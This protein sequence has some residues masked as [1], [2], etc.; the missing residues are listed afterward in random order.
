[1]RTLQIENDFFGDQ[2]RDRVLKSQMDGARSR[3]S[4]CIEELCIFVGICINTNLLNGGL[5]KFLLDLRWS[6]RQL[7]ASAYFASTKRLC[8]LHPDSIKTII[9]L[10]ILQIFLFFIYYEILHHKIFY[11]LLCV[12]QALIKSSEKRKENKKEKRIKFYFIY[13]IINVE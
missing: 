8:L 5:L 13:F 3:Q 2:R 6:L 12:Y 1:M 7:F 9:L 11:S 4:L 10:N